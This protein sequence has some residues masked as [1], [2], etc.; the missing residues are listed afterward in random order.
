MEWTVDTRSQNP[1]TDRDDWK[2]KEY[3]VCMKGTLPGAKVGR[4][5]RIKGELEFIGFQI[6]DNSKKM[7]YYNGPCEGDSGSGHWITIHHIIKRRALV[8]V[9]TESFAKEFQL[10]FFGLKKELTTICGS[11]LNTQGGK[12]VTANW[13]HRTT[14]EDVLKFIKKFLGI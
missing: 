12:A 14:H 7:P 10:D 1:C 11:S 13:A 3:G 2:L 4:F 6:E 5:Q 9:F 8:A